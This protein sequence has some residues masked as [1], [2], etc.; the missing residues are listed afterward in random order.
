MNRRNGRERA[1]S[2]LG[3]LPAK[4]WK[5]MSHMC[6]MCLRSAL[7]CPEQYHNLLRDRPRLQ[8]R[9]SMRTILTKAPPVALDSFRFL[10]LLGDL[11]AVR[12]AEAH[13][14]QTA[15]AKV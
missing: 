9:R 5:V 12:C 2:T 13:R 1:A 6:L 10:D 15:E 11:R 14:A 8:Q 4:P 3:C 7:E